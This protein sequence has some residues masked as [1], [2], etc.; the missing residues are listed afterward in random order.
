M[1]GIAMTEPAQ[2]IN[3]LEYSEEYFLTTCDGYEEYLVGGGAVLTRRLNALWR[4]LRV[5]PGMQVLDIGCGRGEVVVHC[6]LGGADAVGIDYS[7]AGLRLAQQAIVYANGLARVGWRRPHLS[8]GNAR[9]L[10]FQDDAFDRAIMGDVVEHLYPEDLRAA[11]AETYRVLVPGGQ[12]L[13]HTMPNLWY[14]RYG[15]PLFRLVQR[16]RGIS[17]PADP[18]DRFRFSHVHV[19]EQTPRM[20]RKTLAESPFSHWRI[21]LHD[22]REYAQ[23]GPVMRCAMKLLVSVPLINKVFCDDIFV[24]ACK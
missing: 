11:L 6:G 1:T 22:Y 10:P 20:L 12:L 15:Y 24:L 4:F 5:R 19:N 2:P 17:L 14:Y 7:K 3:P 23:Y 21:W 18:R 13:I 8:L 9:Q 16:V